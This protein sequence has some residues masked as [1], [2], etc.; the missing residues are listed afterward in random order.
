MDKVITH[1]VY[2]RICEKAVKE[3]DFEKAAKVY[4]LLCWSWGTVEPWAL[5]V[6]SA[7]QIR[8]E[9][10]RRLQSLWPEVQKGPVRTSSGGLMV[11]FY[12]QA[13]EGPT[14]ELS[15]V[16]VQSEACVAELTSEVSPIRAQP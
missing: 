2:Q 6:P 3:F 12:V 15:F 5:G 10:Q 4:E 9:A 13:E 8:T 11:N 1:V 14:V 16:A 7:K